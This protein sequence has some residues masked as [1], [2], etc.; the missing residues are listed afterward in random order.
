MASWQHR[1]RI[2]EASA[3]HNLLEHA[4]CGFIN[5]GRVVAPPTIAAKACNSRLLRRFAGPSEQVRGRMRR[6][7]I[8]EEAR[9]Q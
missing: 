1:A 6:Y 4:R 7:G 9:R 8:A 3:W 2:E 5:R